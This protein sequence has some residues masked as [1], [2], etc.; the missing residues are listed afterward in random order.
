VR[1]FAALWSAFYYIVAIAALS[2]LI[3]FGLVLLIP[4]VAS[5]DAYASLSEAD[6]P[7]ETVLL[8]KASPSLRRFPYLD[9]AVAVAFC[10][11]D[12][13]KGPVRVKAPLGRAPFTSVSFHSRR[14][15]VFYALT[16]RA[17]THAVID[18]VI[19]TPAQLR[20]LEAAEDEDNPSRDLR[21]V[22]PSNDGYALRRV[23]SESAGLYNAAEDEAKT[24]SCVSEPLAK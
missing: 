11:Y 18:A 3:H 13:G 19:V 14:G 24:L 8:P 20:E 7:E 2:A 12:L 15:A 10:R 1:F 16:D 22:S 23:F 6:T 17:A 5:R 21:I 9:P 4:L